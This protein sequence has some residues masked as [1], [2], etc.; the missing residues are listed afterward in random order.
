MDQNTPHSNY[1][2]ALQKARALNGSQDFVEAEKAA[3][4]AIGLMAASMSANNPRL[5]DAYRLHTNICVELSLTDLGHCKQWLAKA[6][7]SAAH[8]VEVLEL[9]MLTADV[10]EAKRIL[11]AIHFDSEKLPE[12][13]TVLESARVQIIELLDGEKPGVTFADFLGCSNSI[14][15]ALIGLSRDSEAVSLMAGSL[16]KVRAE[17]YRD[18]EVMKNFTVLSMLLTELLAEQAA[19]DAEAG[20]TADQG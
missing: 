5:A 18:L 19:L 7:T 14:A 11:A 9:G 20:D 13:L 8:R 12:A 16:H 4:E 1:A 6:S 10:I 17:H 3:V 2:T 15:Q